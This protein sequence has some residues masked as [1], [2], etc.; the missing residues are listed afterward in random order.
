M[1]RHRFGCASTQCVLLNS[2]MRTLRISRDTTHQ[3]NYRGA[4]W[5]RGPRP[6]LNGARARISHGGLSPA[7]LIWACV[8]RG[9]VPGPG[10]QLCGVCAQRWRTRSRAW[11]LIT[12]ATST[13]CGLRSHCA[14]EWRTLYE[15]AQYWSSCHTRARVA[16]MR[17]TSTESARGGRS[18][19]A[20]RF[21]ATWCPRLEGAGQTYMSAQAVEHVVIA[22]AHAVYIGVGADQVRLRV[23]VPRATVCVSC[24]TTGDPVHPPQQPSRYRNCPIWVSPDTG[25]HV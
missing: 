4:E 19:T 22:N 8:A 7:R 3:S 1:P 11:L 18:L 23:R 13:L 17:R 14:R 12:R 2:E 10:A 21:V 5:F 9:G 25:S 6:R 24:K 20:P 15:R 16:M